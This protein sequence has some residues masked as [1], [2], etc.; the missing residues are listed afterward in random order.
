MAGADGFEANSRETLNDARA[1][2][3][4]TYLAVTE[5]NST[6]AA[7]AALQETDW[8]VQEALD[9]YLQGSGTSART[10]PSN[11]NALD[12]SRAES[13][14]SSGR[15][16]QQQQQLAIQERSTA[17]FNWLTVL[18]SPLRVLWTLVKRFSNLFANL[19]GGHAL[20]IATAPGS[21]NAQR[22]VNYFESRYG[23]THP[24][25][26]DGSYMAAL[27]AAQSDLKFLLV[28]LHSEAH[29]QT[30]RFC[31]SVIANPAFIEAAN[32]TF[33]VWAGSITQPDASA[34]QHALRV[35]GFPFLGI[36]AAPRATVRPTQELPAMSASNFGQLLSSRSGPLIATASAENILQW[37]NM[38]VGRHR[39]ML[40]V[41]REERINRETNR[42]LI[43]QQN[44]EYAEALQADQARERQ[45]QE[46]AARAA[47]EVRRVEERELRRRRKKESLDDEPDKAPGICSVMLRL[48]DGT[49]VE[50]RFSKEDVLEKVFDWAEVNSVDIE[51][52][53]LVTTFPRKSYRYPEDAGLSLEDAGLFPSAML[54]LEE[55]VDEAES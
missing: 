10:N 22:F 14:P 17:R 52:A 19:L 20:A 25:F 23:A 53:C 30:Q 9:N 26:F 5:S 34:A 47:E 15:R 1:E 27:A 41:V 55:R 40:D 39:P 28:Y 44:R 21:T 38:V 24:A 8:N 32:N 43:Q 7:I 4:T 11:T 37:M 42:L 54:L 29:R 31:R 50:R 36:V 12:R 51:V 13:T 33:V 35:Q 18:F 3:L 49:R 6:Q 48:P 2:A 45:E 46:Q 16:S